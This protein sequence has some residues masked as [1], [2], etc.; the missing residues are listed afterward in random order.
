MAFGISP[1]EGHN[2]GISIFED[3]PARVSRLSKKERKGIRQTAK[4]LF[5]AE[6]SGAATSYLAGTRGYT[7]FRPDTLIGKYAAKPIDY[8]QYR[9]IGKT[10]F[11]D[12]LGRDMSDSDWKE[13]TRYAEALG[14]KDPS[15]FQSLLNQR[16]AS[17]P[18]GQARIKS[19]ADIEWESRFGPMA[20][21]PRG[22]LARGFFYYDPS[23][24]AQLTSS[25]LGTT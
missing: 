8:D 6:G 3:F 4:K 18:K 15:E 12:L 20:R 5:K 2:T 24:V 22:N 7:N 11:K 21:D 14:V 16:I 1:S 9:A 19:E 13:A 25:M 23:T 10:S 17:T